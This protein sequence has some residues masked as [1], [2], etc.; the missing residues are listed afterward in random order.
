MNF[1]EALE[2]LKKSKE[3]K[4]WIKEHKEAYLAHGFV[5]IDGKDSTEW[6]IGYYVKKHDKMV[7]F[8]VE[9]EIKVSPET[10]VFKKEATEVNVLDDSKVKIEFKKAVGIF[11]KLQLE[12]ADRPSAEWGIQDGCAFTSSI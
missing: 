4:S 5:M 2:K 8:F 3:F 9:D 7:S 11:K 6:Q 1:K 12:T 10:E